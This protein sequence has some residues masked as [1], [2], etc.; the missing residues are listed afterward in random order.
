MPFCHCG[1]GQP[2]Q[3]CCEPYVTGQ[4][5]AP[6]AEALMRSRYSAYVEGAVDY[7]GETLHPQHRADWDREATRRWSEDAQWLGLEIVATEAG[8]QQDQQGMVEFI[9]SFKENGSEKRHQE[10]SRFARVNERWYYV[11]GEAPKPKTQRHSTPRVGRN[12][13][14]SC[15]SGKKFKK[16]C[17]A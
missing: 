17:G 8:R 3:T 10:C 14:C 9:A 13:P 4:E 5:N 12:D 15:G 6:T 2:Y 7:L 16:C 1:S 11:D